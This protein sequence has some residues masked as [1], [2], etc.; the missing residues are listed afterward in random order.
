[1]SDVP[2][3][4]DWDRLGEN[5][6]TELRVQ[7]AGRRLNLPDPVVAGLAEGLLAEVRYA[8][9]VRWAPKWVRSGDPHKWS[10]PGDGGTTAHYVD[11]IRCRR[12]SVHPGPAEADAWYAEHARANHPAD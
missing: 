12:L 9:D 6:L 4:D 2:Y 7:N 10:E 11:C 5:I 3:P 8:F 1:M